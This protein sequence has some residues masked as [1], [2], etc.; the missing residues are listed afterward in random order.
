MVSMIFI[1]NGLGKIL[2]PDLAGKVVQSE[3]FLMFVGVIL[4]VAVVLFLNNKT[5]VWGASILA[6]YMTF[7]T[8]IHWYKGKPFEIV[9]LIVVCTIFAT[10]LRQPHFFHG[11]KTS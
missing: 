10:Y 7:I 6:S 5:I 3:A 4:I 11:D 9:A 1:Q 8:C 2:N